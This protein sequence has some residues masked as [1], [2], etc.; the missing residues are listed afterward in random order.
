M[1]V[2]FKGKNRGGVHE[3]SG[4]GWLAEVRLLKYF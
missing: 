4:I 3:L 2:G 1:R